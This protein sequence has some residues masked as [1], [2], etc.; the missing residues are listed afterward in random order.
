MATMEKTRDG[1]ATRAPAGRPGRPW[2][3]VGDGER[4]LSVVGGGALAVLGLRARSA[5]GVALAAAGGLL[6]YR[7][8]SGHSFVYAAAGA[9]SS[10][11]TGP[12]ASVAAGQGV[13]VVQAVT[14]NKPAAE[15][16]RTWRQFENLPKFMTHLVSVRGE[17]NRSHWVAK[18]PA[19]TTVGWDAEIV[20]DEPNRLIAWRSLEGAAVASAGSV[21]FDEAPGGRGTE[22]RVSLKYDPPGGRLGSWLA[23]LFGEEPSWQV[24]EDLMRFKALCEAGEVPTV[25]GQPS[26]RQAKGVRS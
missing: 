22:V 20:T 26:G 18:A 17:G 21:R 9:H 1:A 5:G 15:L 3:N 4:L 16:Y 12:R 7:G 24:R 19:G 13:K 14:I 8:L 11:P 10:R 23:W 6:L 2:V 25:A